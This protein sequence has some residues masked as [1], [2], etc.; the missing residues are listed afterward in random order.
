MD[1]SAQYFH[2]AYR[3]VS[4]LTCVLHLE[5]ESTHDFQVDF[6]LMWIR[7]YRDKPC[8]TKKGSWLGTNIW[9]VRYGW[10]RLVEPILIAWPKPL[11]TEFGIHEIIESCDRYLVEKCVYCSLGLEKSFQ[12]E[13][14]LYYFADRGRETNQN[15]LSCLYWGSYRKPQKSNKVFRLKQQT[16]HWK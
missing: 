15:R 4:Q 6:T 12:K 10:T 3:R 5:P 1:N 11:L 9:V 2:Q 13:N 7:I 8:A 16:S 14:S